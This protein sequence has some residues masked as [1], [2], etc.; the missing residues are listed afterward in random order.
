M[1]SNSRS[2]AT[3][4]GAAAACL[5]VREGARAF[6]APSVA[7]HEELAVSAAALRGAAAEQPTATSSLPLTALSVAV[8]GA[9][10]LQV[11]SRRRA[12]H[13]RAQAVVRNVVA[14][15]QAP[16]TTGTKT[17]TEAK[18][19]ADVLTQVAANVLEAE[20]K[21]AQSQARLAE[22]DA[23]LSRAQAGGAE[24]Q[25]LKAQIATVEEARKQAEA[26][27]EAS[28]KGMAIMEES[29]R[30][31]FEAVHEINKLAANAD[32]DF[33]KL[34]NHR[35]WQ[36]SSGSGPSNKITEAEVRNALT[37][38]GQG[39]VDIGTVFRGYGDF[40]TK[41]AEMIRRLYAYDLY[42]VLFKP[43]KASQQ[44]FRPT[45][46]GALSYF[47]GGNPAF[48]E[49]H[50][51]AIKPWSKVRIE[52]GTFSLNEDTATVMGNYW[53]SDYTYTETKV[54]FTFGYK[55]DST[56]KLRIILHHSSL[57][58]SH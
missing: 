56:G 33:T 43:T 21:L 55:R 22:K 50:G 36:G 25:A 58:Y 40:K 47:V 48:A 17:N 52:P 2:V 37:E 20:K 12:S 49:D 5:A 11:N 7:V 54:E 6:T 16:T 8:V 26:R 9:G 44:P 57:P 35:D 32:Y 38:W 10:A 51:F 18:L 14:G 29:A 23:A 1:S 39:I 27:A 4:I 28:E 34:V 30:L 53:F 31:H 41:A 13:S 15:V 42:P 3:I 46:E 45:F 24:I 19:L